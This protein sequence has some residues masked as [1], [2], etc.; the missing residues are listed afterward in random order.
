[1]P[2]L[3]PK[4]SVAL[5]GRWVS[6][7]WQIE[8]LTL[9]NFCLYCDLRNIEWGGSQAKPGY[10]LIVTNSLCSLYIYIGVA[11]RRQVMKRIGFLANVKLYFHK[12]F[13]PVK[14]GLRIFSYNNS[15]ELYV[16]YVY[17]PGVKYLKKP[18]HWPGPKYLNKPMHFQKIPGVG[19]TPLEIYSKSESAGHHGKIRTDP[20]NN[21]FLVERF[22]GHCRR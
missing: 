9:S 3:G 8:S 7:L 17:T 19:L 14:I 22:S 2:V 15:K 4:S 10:N 1:M 5:C 20:E 12:H 21:P 16:L 11:S 13:F 6:R 18:T